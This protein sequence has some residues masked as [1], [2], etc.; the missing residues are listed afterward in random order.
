[1]KNN[2]R[3]DHQNYIDSSA[4]CFYVTLPYFGKHSEKLKSDLSVLFCKY[5]KDISFN[6]ILVNSFKIDSFF[7]FKDRLPKGMRSSLIYKYSCVRCT[8]EYIGSTTR[9]LTTRVAEHAGRSHRTDRILANPPHSNI[10]DHAE[11]CGSPI[12]L[13]NFNIID[14]CNNSNDLRILESLYIHK[15]R[16]SLNNM[17][18]AHPLYIVSK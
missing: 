11:T 6:F 8:S 16:P 12:V 17:Q 10:R 7:S 18:S 9:I 5:F 13:D 2:N 14:S 15:E 4:Q 3:Y 1:M